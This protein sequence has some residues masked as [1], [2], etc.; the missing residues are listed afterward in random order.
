M[1]CGNVC[2]VFVVQP[3]AQVIGGTVKNILVLLV[4]LQASRWINDSRDSKKKERLKELDDSL[5]VISLSLNNELYIFMP[6]RS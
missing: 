1:V 5:K 4:L 2:Y 6:K 3:L